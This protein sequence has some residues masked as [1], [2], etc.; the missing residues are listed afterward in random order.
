MPQ[1]ISI[2]LVEDSPSDV[3]LTQE[4]LKDTK[5][6]HE[7]FVVNDG[8]QAMMY[9]KECMEHGASHLPNMILLDL[10]M[11]KKNGHEVL[12]EIKEV[13][14]FAHI[15]V[16][17]L[18]VSQQDKDIME[19][20]TLRMNYYLRK[21]IESERLAVLI[22]AISDLTL[23][24]GAASEKTAD[25]SD[26]QVRLVLAGNP[27]TSQMVLQKLSIEDDHRIRARVAENPNTPASVLLALSRDENADVRLGVS[28]NPNTPGSVLETLAKD[29]SDDVRLGM[30]SNPHLSQTILKNLAKDDNVFV[31]DNASKTLSSLSQSSSDS[32]SGRAPSLSGG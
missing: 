6:P 29:A 27:H 4:A 14:E 31:A 18:T 12:A 7:L 30:A 2:L 19:A 25:P 28:E 13:K 16:I 21:P 23:A 32:D 9:M 8:E 1:R 11:P 15:P 3:R 26:L 24:D 17:L 22:K 10:N 20:L 5:I